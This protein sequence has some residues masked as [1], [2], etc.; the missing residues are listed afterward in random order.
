M[1]S[2]VPILR[3]VPIPK[4]VVQRTTLRSRGEGVDILRF[5]RGCAEYEYEWFEESPPKFIPI[6][7]TTTKSRSM[8]FI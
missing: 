7:S 4:L 3:E 2:G 5:I 1:T 8:K 6:T